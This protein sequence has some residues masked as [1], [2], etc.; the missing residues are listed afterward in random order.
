MSLLI[1]DVKNAGERT[2]RT[3]FGLSGFRYIGKIE[4]LNSSKAVGL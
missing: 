4:K 1:R 3:N 2:K